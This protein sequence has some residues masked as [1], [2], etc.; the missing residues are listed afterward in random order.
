M[1]DIFKVKI[2]SSETG[3]LKCFNDIKSLGKLIKN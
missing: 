2:K 3:N 1:P